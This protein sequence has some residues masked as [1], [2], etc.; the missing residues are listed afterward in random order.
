M[1][2]FSS[3]NKNIYCD[4]VTVRTLSEEA[5]LLKGIYWS[6]REGKPQYWLDPNATLSPQGMAFGLALLPP[7]R[8]SSIFSLYSYLTGEL[9]YPRKTSPT[10]CWPNVGQH[11][12]LHPNKF[13]CLGK[14]HILVFGLRGPVTV[15]TET[16]CLNY[17]GHVPR[18]WLVVG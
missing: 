17:R 14:C 16:I 15:A 13:H 2:L 1:A 9:L 6:Q 3:F 4:L 8:F 12:F 10:F 18:L 11:P 5:S 7:V